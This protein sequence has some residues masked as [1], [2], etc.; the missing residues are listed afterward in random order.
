MRGGA[1]RAVMTGMCSRAPCPCVLAVP[2]GDSPLLCAPELSAAALWGGDVGL[3][4]AVGPGG[5]STKQRRL[6][7]TPLS[8]GSQG[9]GCGAQLRDGRSSLNFNLLSFPLNPLSYLCCRA[10]MEAARA[11]TELAVMQP[12]DAGDV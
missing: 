3:R 5:L 10:L 7:S 6:C 2:E 1:V 11:S 9:Q 4:W 8:A 12:L